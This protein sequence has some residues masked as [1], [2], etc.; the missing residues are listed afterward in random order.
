MMID[1]LADNITEGGGTIIKNI[2]A[3]KFIPVNGSISAVELADGERIEAKYFISNTHPEQV[4]SMLGEMKVPKAFSHRVNTLEDTIGMFTLYLV[5]KKECFPYLNHNFYHYNQDNVWLAG[6]Y[7]PSIWPQAY[8]LMCTASSK[9]KEY[10]E[11]ASVLTYMKFSE[12]QKWKDTFTGNRGNDY[13][14]FKRRKADLLLKTVERE[15]PGISGC[16]EAFYTSTPLTW[17]DYTGTR[18]G[19][20]YGLMKDYN[21][22]MESIILPRTKIPNL[23]LTGQNTNMHGILGVTISAVLT[24]GE[25]V[26]LRKLIADIRNA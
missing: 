25:L 26:N 6:N 10:A 13:E 7:D 18:G 22:P 2:A 17:R 24:C 9:S 20:A 1:I 14:E 3:R 16:V 23:L 15:F 8:V 19:S 21:K 4:I 12:L 11:S 5:F